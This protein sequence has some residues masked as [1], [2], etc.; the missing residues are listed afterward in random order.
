M[1]NI[2]LNQSSSK[3]LN[4]LHPTL[5]FYLSLAVFFI[6]AALNQWRHVPLFTV[7]IAFLTPVILWGLYEI[8]GFT[9]ILF[10]F[11]ST[12]IVS[13]FVHLLHYGIQPK[14]ISDAIYISCFATSY[15]Y[16]RYHRNSLKAS[17]IW[18]LAGVLCLMFS[19]SFIGLNKEKWLLD[20]DKQHSI[21]EYAQRKDQSNIASPTAP[22]WGKLEKNRQ[23]HKGLFRV[24]HV[25][26]LLLGLCLL[27]VL[28]IPQTLRRSWIVLASL[29]M[30][31]F[32]LWSGTRIFFAA[33]AA[34]VLI[35]VVYK[36]NYLLLFIAILL[37]IPVVYFRFELYEL[38]RNTPLG[39][40]SGA[41]IALFDEWHN[42]SRITIWSVWWNE[43]TTFN[44]R[45]W[46]IGKG[47]NQGLEVNYALLD[48]KVWFHN[49]FLSI[50][51]SY[52]FFSFVLFILLIISWFI[53]ARKS[54]QE[55]MGFFLFCSVLIISAILNGLYF[56][57]P[58]LFFYLFFLMQDRSAPFFSKI[59]SSQVSKNTTKNI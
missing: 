30:L 37:F 35:F 22:L 44:L 11:L 20:K 7:Y 43:I 3:L 10:L 58:L 47:F 38:T 9:R 18:V 36:R 27:A 56:Y 14:N 59:K 53:E 55:H 57:Q 12:L 24:P 34:A 51:Y 31:F 50:M 21:I 52:G 39:S 33:F 2:N 26:A 40:L 1:D 45:E 5:I 17:A 23:Y 6:D 19:F 15:Y 46:I 16:Y 42:F 13:S 41:L 4:R 8:G 48:Y 25:G 32:I 28:F 54:L 29:I 49:D